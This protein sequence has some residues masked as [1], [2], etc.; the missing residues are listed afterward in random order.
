[1]PI[2]DLYQKTLKNFNEYVELL[3]ISVLSRAKEIDKQI[4]EEMIEIYLKKR[5]YTMNYVSGKRIMIKDFT[6]VYY[7]CGILEIWHDVKNSKAMFIK[8]S[9]LTNLPIMLDYM[10]KI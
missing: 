9:L 10:E 1:M 2:E 4:T 3:H 8:E 6:C 7:D 5:G